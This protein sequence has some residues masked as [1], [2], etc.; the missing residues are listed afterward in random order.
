MKPL[1]EMFDEAINK[2]SCAIAGDN[3]D[4]L[5]QTGYVKLRKVTITPTRKIFEAPE[6][7]MGNR[8]LRIDPQ[9]YPP[10][11]FLR[12]SF[13]DEDWT[14]I[15]PNIGKAFIERFLRHELMNGLVV[16]GKSFSSI[17]VLLMLMCLQIS[18]SQ[19]M[20][21][22]SLGCSGILAHRTARCES[23]VAIS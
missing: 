6:L 22:R 8:I 4:D 10:T 20:G 1:Y 19:S 2:T 11:K 16:A 9:N 18:T 13:R 12:V 21:I 7:I 17:C 5:L 14:H 3:H 23:R 15:R